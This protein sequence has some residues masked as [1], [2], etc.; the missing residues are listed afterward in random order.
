MTESSK[1]DAFARAEALLAAKR[2]EETIFLVGELRVLDARRAGQVL[3]RAVGGLAKQA[4]HEWRACRFDKAIRCFETIPAEMHDSDISV[5]LIKC[6]N[7]RSLQGEILDRLQDGPFGR[8]DEHV[9]AKV[10]RYLAE[11]ALEGLCDDRVQSLLDV[12][13]SGSA[14][15]EK[16]TGV[17]EAVNTT[18]F[19]VGSIT[20]AITL[21]IGAG[22]AIAWAFSAHRAR[23]DLRQAI[24]LKQ[25]DRALALDATNVEALLGRARAE[26]ATASADWEAALKDIGLAEQNGGS[27][28]EIRRLRSLALARRALQAARLGRI[29]DAEA[30][31]ATAVRAGID[32]KNVAE[33]NEAIASAWLGRAERASQRQDLN[34][35]KQ[36]S[37]AAKKSPRSTKKLQE[38]WVAQAQSCIER[39][40]LAGFAEACHE[41]TANG[42]PLAEVTSLWL[43]FGNAAME[44]RDCA[45][46]DAAIEA[47]A[48]TNARD[49]DMR[50][51]Q[52]GSAIL[53]S[54]SLARA[55]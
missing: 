48:K 37:M 46:L 31:L 22:G 34:A 30:D 33:V 49:L 29:D 47:A 45:A 23:V 52:A 43:A 20:L 26:L 16:R 13:Q 21:L 8:N 11:L 40:D 32:E 55:D 44:K 18:L 25:W 2:Y 42:L 50:P 14:K 54:L 35:L 53:R 15:I 17:Y 5:A 28:A 38:L 7:L 27:I 51:L 39:I 6:R 24:A 41:A 3:S 1:H 12:F 4:D 19:I 10:K 36:A 9:V